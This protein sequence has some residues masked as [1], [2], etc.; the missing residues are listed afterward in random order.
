[1]PQMPSRQ[2]GSK[3]IGSSPSCVELLV[4]HVEH[5]QERHVLGDVV[6]LVGVHGALGAGFAWRQILRVTHVHL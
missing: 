2:S 1:M 6:D 5:L 3:A 4:E